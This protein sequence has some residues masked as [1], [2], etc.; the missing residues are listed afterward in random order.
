MFFF[1]F[2]FALRNTESRLILT[3]MHSLLSPS[4]FPQQMSVL[5]FSCVILTLAFSD[6]NRHQS[7]CV[8]TAWN[9]FHN[10]AIPL[11]HSTSTRRYHSSTIPSEKLGKSGH[12]RIYKGSLKGNNLINLFL[13]SLSPFYIFA[14]SEESK[15]HK[16]DSPTFL[17]KMIPIRSLIYHTF[18]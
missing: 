2:V 7:L 18:F 17:L 9:K 12:P 5:S 16:T 10:W 14:V 1:V 6:M 15:S 13:S 4:E 3:Q 8:P 11:N